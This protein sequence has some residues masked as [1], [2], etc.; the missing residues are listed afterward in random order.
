VI[1]KIPEY[2]QKDIDE[3]NINP[4]NDYNNNITHYIGDEIYLQ[5]WAPK[6]SSETLIFGR[7][8]KLKLYLNNKEYE[9][10]FMAFN[11]ALRKNISHENEFADI[12]DGYD[13]SNDAALE[14]YIWKLYKL[15]YDSSLN[16]PESINRLSSILNR[17]FS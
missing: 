2:M 14:T 5:A 9:D 7:N 4:I 16:I 13:N 8:L 1:E 10:K 6:S 12:T 17:K 15:N 3:T 11:A